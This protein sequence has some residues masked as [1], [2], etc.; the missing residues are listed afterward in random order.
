MAA[1]LLAFAT[2]LVAAQSLELHYYKKSGPKAELIIKRKM[3]QHFSADP[4]LPAGLLR[5][6]FHDCFIRLCFQL[7]TFSLFAFILFHIVDNLLLVLFCL[8]LSS[9]LRI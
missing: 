7:L 4:S 8:F 1:F 2:L 3:Q 5:L 6:H 9:F